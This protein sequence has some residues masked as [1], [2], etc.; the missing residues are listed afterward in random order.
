MKIAIAKTSLVLISLASALGIRTSL[1]QE[2][3]KK[4]QKLPGIQKE[5]A[6]P[7]TSRKTRAFGEVHKHSLGLGLGQTVL[8]GGFNDHGENKITLDAYYNYSASYSFELL[9]NFHYS[10]H[11]FK[12]ESVILPG[13]ATAIKG[14]IFQFDSFAP[15]AFGGLGFY[16]PQAE[17]VINNTIVKSEQ[18]WTF[19]TNFGLGVDLKLNKEFTFGILAHYHNPFDIKQEV[20][21][22]VEGSYFKVLLTTMYTF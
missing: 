17:R 5:K 19:G 16:R 2:A 18:K 7:A 14:K 8:L 21:T 1:A 10:E 9:V 3:N 22:E 11:E 12:N 15:Y 6:K 13:L 4:N 20:G